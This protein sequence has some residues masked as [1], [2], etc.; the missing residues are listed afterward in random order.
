[1]HRAWSQRTA[2]ESLAR[3]QV[4]SGTSPLCSVIHF[5]KKHTIQEWKDA[6][7][8]LDEYLGFDEWK[9]TDDDPFY[10]W[11]LVRKVRELRLC[12]DMPS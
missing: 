12:M 2:P 5:I 9:K 4:I 11:R 6:A 8:V 7:L 1:L 10:D 3:L